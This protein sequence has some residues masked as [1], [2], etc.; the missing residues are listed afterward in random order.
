MTAMETCQ[1]ETIIEVYVVAVR[2]S[3]FISFA[4]SKVIETLGG[5]TIAISGFIHLH[6]RINGVRLLG[7]PFASPVVFIYIA[8][9]CDR[10]RCHHTRCRHIGGFFCLKDD[11]DIAGGLLCLG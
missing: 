4:I 11:L 3:L 10:V 9:L 1:T 5:K 6:I 2:K 7:W 8:S